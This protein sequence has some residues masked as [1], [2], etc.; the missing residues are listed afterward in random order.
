M[1]VRESRAAARVQIVEEHVRAENAHD[2]DA[3]S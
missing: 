3:L 2:L 1:D